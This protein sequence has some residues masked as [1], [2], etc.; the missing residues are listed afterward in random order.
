MFNVTKIA[1]HR[2]R[3]ALDTETLFLYYVTASLFRVL[4]VQYQPSR[5][6]YFPS[7]GRPK[8]IPTTGFKY[9][10]MSFAKLRFPLLSILNQHKSITNR[11]VFKTVARLYV[12]HVRHL[13]TEHISRQRPILP[14]VHTTNGKKM[15]NF[16]GERPTVKGFCFVRP[17]SP[18]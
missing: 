15:D 11:S 8:S 5:Q 7:Y 4:N 10:G 13:R 2:Y 17:R 16:G 18:Y 1:N 9:N 12:L 3:S 6:K 14:R